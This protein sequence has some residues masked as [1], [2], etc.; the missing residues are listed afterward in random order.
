MLV[1]LLFA[2]FSIRK[3]VP[4]G[5]C[6]KNLVVHCVRIPD[7]S[8]TKMLQDARMSAS[9]GRSAALASHGRGPLWAEIDVAVKD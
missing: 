1:F 8:T 9:T 6:Y 5:H 3:L 7:V 2:F 4:S